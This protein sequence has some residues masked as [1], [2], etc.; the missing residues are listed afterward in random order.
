MWCLIY[1]ST[2]ELP[3]LPCESI[4]ESESL[5]LVIQDQLMR[6]Y[7]EIPY[8]CSD[9]LLFSAGEFAVPEIRLDSC[10]FLSSYHRIL[11][12]VSGLRKKR[13]DNGA[14]IVNCVFE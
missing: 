4:N 9:R 14:D 8:G 7:A 1:I 3:G 13:T 11:L 12:A 6:S 5:E 2:E 10:G